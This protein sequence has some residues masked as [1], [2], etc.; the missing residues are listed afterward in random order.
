MRDPVLFTLLPRCHVFSQQLQSQLWPSGTLKCGH[1]GK[2]QLVCDGDT[3]APCLCVLQKG[4]QDRSPYAL[5]FHRQVSVPLLSV[6]SLQL[7]SEQAICLAVLPGI[8]SPQD[9][10]TDTSA[11]APPLVGGRLEPGRTQGIFQFL[12]LL[13]TA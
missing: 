1:S 11:E 6:L 4:S 3:V 5:K 7:L 2:Q 10:V 9:C 13:L 12:P 8:S